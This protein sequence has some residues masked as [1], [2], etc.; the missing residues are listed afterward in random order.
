[1]ASAL[2]SLGV[3]KNKIAFTLTNDNLVEMEK[4]Y[5][6]SKKLKVEFTM[7]AMQN[8]DIY[9]GNKKSVLKVDRDKLK[10]S[11]DYIIKNELQ[12]WSL[13]KWARA[14][15]AFGLYKF[16][17]NSLR[18]L[19]SEAGNLHFFMDPTGDIYPSVVDNKKMGN[20]KTVK[21]IKEIWCSTKTKELQKRLKQGLAKS[22]W[23]ICTAR[24][25]IK[26]HPLKV[27]R[28]VIKNKFKL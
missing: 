3:K 19:P 7:S 26:K 12:S 23:M 4:V 24:T 5:N 27:V 2:Q 9:F 22:S 17:L 15:Y 11:F 20:L 8:S 25:S 13:K 6:L 10:E 14:Y 1:M 28:W 21:N 16:L 18:E